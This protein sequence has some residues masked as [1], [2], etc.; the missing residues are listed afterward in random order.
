MPPVIVSLTSIPRRNHTL[1]PTITSLLN[2]QRPPDE[3]RLYLTPGC[4][5]VAGIRCYDVV[6]RGPVTK[7]SAAVDPYLP[8]EALIVTV[9]DDVLYA[10]TWLATLVEAANA[11]PT[12]AVGR[13]GWDANDFITNPIHG[14]YVWATGDTC[15]VLEGWSGVAYRRGFFD[16]TILEPPPA[17]HHVDDVWI[18][19][20]LAK[21]G[22]GRRLVRPQLATARTDS[23][24]G[25]HNRPDFLT[26]NRR[27]AI[28]AFT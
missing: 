9:D 16:A 8:A 20:Y 15:D 14:F 12:C 28:L 27:A 17:F 1:G 25:L 7:L 4:E 18:S 23:T 5:H 13:S 2:Q 24:P 6:D 19:G 26:L 10:P 21:R 3:I 11:M 22:I